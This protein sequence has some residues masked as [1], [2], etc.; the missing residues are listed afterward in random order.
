MKKDIIKK[1]LYYFPIGFAAFILSLFICYPVGAQEE[2][3]LN[4]ANFA[5][6]KTFPGVQLERY[7]KEIE[8]RTNGKIKIQAYHGGTLL[9]AKNMIE[10]VISGAA[11]IGTFPPGYL[12]GRYPLLELFNTQ[13]GWPSSIVATATLYDL[14]KK[15]DLESKSIKKLKVLAVFTG[16]PAHILSSIPIR[17]RSDLKTAELRATV[18]WVQAL[19]LLGGRPIGM[20]MPEVPEAIKKGVVKGLV[21]SLDTLMDFN[22]AEYTRFVTKCYLPV[23]PW[24]VFM[25][26]DKWDS[27]PPEAKKVFEDL[28]KDH[29]LWTAKYIDKHEKESVNW[30]KTKY[31]VEIINLSSDELSNWHSLLKPLKNPYM[32]LNINGIKGRTFWNELLK[33][34]AKNIKVYAK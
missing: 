15:F 7:K 28:E 11:D 30:A 14:F 5:P 13:V 27:L 8:K 31:N 18:T 24:V 25:N 23:A 4:S 21:S 19:E 26:Q 10:G 29:S 32:D 6:A 1:I 20:P 22:F 9:G 16:T 2:I 3:V 34:Q 33:M 12:T 17:N